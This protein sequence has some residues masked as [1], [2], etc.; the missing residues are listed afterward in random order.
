MGSQPA[1]ANGFPAFDAFHA[2]CE[3]T[4]TVQSKC[5]DVY[6]T[7]FKELSNFQDPASGIYKVHSDDGSSNVWVTRTTPTK[8]YVDDIEFTFTVNSA[9]TCKID[10]KSRSQ[11]FSIYDYDTNYCNMYN[12]IRESGLKFSPVATSSCANVPK[13][14]DVEATCNKY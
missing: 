8:H 5:V 13:A 14:A 11:T 12:P 2:H 1:A 10:A 6:G 4:T 3:M 9:T 7:M